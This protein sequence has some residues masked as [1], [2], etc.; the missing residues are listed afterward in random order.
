[1]Q[2]LHLLLNMTE[3]KNLRHELI[4]Q[5]LHL[6]AVNKVPAFNQFE[7]MSNYEQTSIYFLD[8]EHLH[9][10]VLLWKKCI[11]IDCDANLVLR[12]E[13]RAEKNAGRS[14]STCPGAC[15]M[16]ETNL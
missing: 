11:Y 14:G 6:C 3:K 10:A 2:N 8:K 9:W 12:V 4:K 16:Q 15:V 5:Q 7:P 13:Y 1:M